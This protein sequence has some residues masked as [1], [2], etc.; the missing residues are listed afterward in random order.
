MGQ[1]CETRVTSDFGGGNVPDS[2]KE[3]R[4]V[5]LAVSTADR[6]FLLR[7]AADVLDR[8]EDELD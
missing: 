1:T 4:L 7:T 3:A 2:F 5:L 6:R 8:R